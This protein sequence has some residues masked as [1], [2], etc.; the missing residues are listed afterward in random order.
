ML[1]AYRQRRGAEQWPGAKETDG[2]GA[3]AG[4]QGSVGDV[5]G[6]LRGEDCQ[7][8]VVESGVGGRAVCWDMP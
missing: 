2:E 7:T 4:I 8:L 6:T 1:E 5:S 3:R